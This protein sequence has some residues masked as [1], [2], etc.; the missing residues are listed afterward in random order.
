[1][2]LK[3]RN[4]KEKYYIIVI[5]NNQS[6]KLRSNTYNHQKCLS[7]TVQYMKIRK[8]YKAHIDSLKLQIHKPPYNTSQEIA[9]ST[10]VQTSTYGYPQIPRTSKYQT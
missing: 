3:I 6:R 5:H 1:M 9:K 4:D 8:P 2:C 10:N 7:S